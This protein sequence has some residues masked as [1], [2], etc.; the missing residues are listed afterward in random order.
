M[1]DDSRSGRLSMSRTAD[2]VERMKQMVCGDC[3]LT[4]Q[5]VADELEINCDSVEDLCEDGA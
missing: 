5:M 4:V 3:Q 2:N 1:E